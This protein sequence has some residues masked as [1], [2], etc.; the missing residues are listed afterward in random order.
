MSD[1]PALPQ[2]GGSYIRK[3]DGSLDRVEYTRQ[4]GEPE[5]PP[6]TVRQPLSRKPAHRDGDR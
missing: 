5:A 1:K 3:P 2:E 4:P 6:E